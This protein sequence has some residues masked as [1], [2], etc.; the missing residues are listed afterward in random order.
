MATIE[1][2]RVPRGSAALTLGFGTSVAMWVVCYLSR[3]PPALV[4]NWVLATLL[5]LCLLGGGAVAGGTGRGG[6]RLGACAGL[7]TS[8]VNLLILGSLLGGA[9]AGSVAPSALVFIPGSLL[10]GAALGA[11]GAA[12]VGGRG[13]SA[14]SVTNWTGVFA[15]I[16]AVATLLQLLV[17]G[18]VTSEGAGLAVTDWP[19]SFGYN[20]FLYPLSRMTGGVFYEHAHRLFGTLVGLTTVVLAVQLL[21]AEPRGWV[22]RLGLAAVVLVVVQ[23]ILGGLRVTGTFTLATTRD[24]M[25]P[26]IAL[27]AAHG[28]LGPVFFAVMVA[29]AVVTSATWIGAAE[30]RPTPAAETDRALG[31]LLVG[32]LLVQLVLGALQ[33]HL[34]RGLMVHVS[35]AVVVLVLAVTY[36]ARVWGLHGDLP[37][38][39]RLARL[40][41]VAAGVQVM[42]GVLA[43]VAVSS[44]VEGAPREAWQVLL[45]TAHQGTGAALLGCATALWLWMFRLLAPEAKR[46]G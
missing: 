14:S 9:R 36:G 17:G 6:W 13:P 23:G 43:L 2:D 18:L 22:K 15:A 46:A 11:A 21:R 40:L 32:A 19:N 29:I 4:P 28:V 8:L 27:A 10:L 26:S 5:L 7:V 44:R 16:A 41:S 45:T 3:L 35:F 42:L 25:S 34:T 38:L 39:R 33:R 1:G 12:A 31:G 24:A 37:L 20:M 30:P